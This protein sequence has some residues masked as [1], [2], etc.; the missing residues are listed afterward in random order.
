[1]TKDTDHRG[2]EDQRH[3]TDLKWLIQSAGRNIGLVQAFKGHPLSPYEYA[4]HYEALAKRQLRR[5]S[6]ACPVVPSNDYMAR[7]VREA[8]WLFRQPVSHGVVFFKLVIE[9][10]TLMPPRE[11]QLLLEM[12]TGEDF[13]VEEIWS[14]PANVGDGEGPQ[15]SRPK[16]EDAWY[17]QSLDQELLIEDTARLLP[18]ALGAQAI[19]DRL[20]IPSTRF[21]NLIDLGV[22]P[23]RPRWALAAKDR[24]SKAW[25]MCWAEEDL[26]A[27]ERV[28]SKDIDDEKGGAEHV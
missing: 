13:S 21:A 8:G 17:S 23:K 28:L 1:M 11:A 18:K 19:C 7:L 6:L 12:A 27:L 24:G 3:I 25:V 5:L 22:I 9:V 16:D 2:P 20:K 4:W 10:E 26:E 14:R 15:L